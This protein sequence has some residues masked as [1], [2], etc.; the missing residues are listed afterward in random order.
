MEKHED[1]S[2]GLYVAKRVTE[3]NDNEWPV[4]FQDLCRTRQLSS[5]MHELNNLL[6]EAK[7]AKLARAAMKKMG[8]D[9]NMTQH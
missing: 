8:F 2:F 3:L 4:F 9:I 5:A 7:H 1:N 6:T